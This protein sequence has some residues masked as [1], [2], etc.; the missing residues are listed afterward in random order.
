MGAPSA[1]P[2]PPAPPLSTGPESVPAPQPPPDPPVPVPPSTVPPSAMGGGP[3][4][5][6]G[7]ALSHVLPSKHVGAAPGVATVISNLAV[8]PSE[9][10]RML[11]P[12]GVVQ[13]APS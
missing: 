4:W 8:S 10:I 5:Q 12:C 7:A 9:A 1:P 3:G 13:A 11:T 6:T 2:A